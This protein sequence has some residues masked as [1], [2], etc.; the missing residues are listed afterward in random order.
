MKPFKLTKLPYIK[1]EL[2]SV[3]L[4]LFLGAIIHNGIGYLLGYWGSKFF[5][6]FIGKIGYRLGFFLKPI[7]LIN[8][9]E[10]RTIAFEVGMQNGGMASGLAIDVLNSYSSALPPNVFGTWMNISG[11]M[12]ANYWKQ[13]PTK[14]KS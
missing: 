14:S 1:I 12:L 6:K 10:S 7:S 5:G 4:L 8:E 9:S 11:S 13:N 3:G 2:R